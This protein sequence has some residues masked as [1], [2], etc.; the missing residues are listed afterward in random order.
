[1]FFYQHLNRQSFE[2]LFCFLFPSVVPCEEEYS[3]LLQFY[4][5]GSCHRESQA[6]FSSYGQVAMGTY[7][8]CRRGSIYGI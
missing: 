3:C 1:M 2:A 6:P 7:A 5:N 8:L 4:L